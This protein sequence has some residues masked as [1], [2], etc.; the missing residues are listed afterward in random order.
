MFGQ[1]KTGIGVFDMRFT[2]F[3]NFKT[4]ILQK[5]DNK[6]MV[7]FFSELNFFSSLTYQHQDEEEEM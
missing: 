6:M 1:T 4:I 7:D 3:F 5:L 2:Q